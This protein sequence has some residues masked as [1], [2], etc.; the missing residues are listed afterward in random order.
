[1]DAHEHEKP[2]EGRID[3]DR[4]LELRGRAWSWS[5]VAGAGLLAIYLLV[6]G[7]A[8][9]LEHALDELLD[10]WHWMVPLVLGFALQVGLYAYARRATRGEGTIHAHGVATSGGASTL[11][12][13]ACCAHHLADVL[14]LIGMAGAAMFLAEYQALFLLLG[15]LSNVVGLVYVRGLLS[16]HGLYPRKTSL[17]SIAARPRLRYALPAVAVLCVVLFA[18]AVMRAIA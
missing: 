8:N 4:H 12:M 13:V 16:Q 17:L 2:S 11:S 9:S 5:L 3:W 18:I 7:L 1:M 14:P 10:L 6:L 15:V